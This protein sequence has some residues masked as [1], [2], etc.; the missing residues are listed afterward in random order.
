MNTTRLHDMRI[1]RRGLSRMPGGLRATLLVLVLAMAPAVPADDF[2]MSWFTIDDGGGMWGAGGN[3][4]LSGTIGQPDAGT[5]TGGAFELSGGFWVSGLFSPARCVGDLN[6]DG[7][8][9]FGD[10]N[11]F[12]Q[13]L[14]NYTGWQATYPSCNPLN[15][16]INSD[17]TYGQG[18]FGD[19]NPFVS[20]LSSGS[21]PIMCP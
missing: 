13:Y 3:Y 19:I 7:K 10:I 20:L 12:V 2:T 21:L 4:Q 6:C 17:G 16:D 5:M 8:I 1:A 18:S 9:D 14:S 11:P 15:G